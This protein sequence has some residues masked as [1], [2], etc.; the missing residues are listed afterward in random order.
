M[1][2][3]PADGDAV[4]KHSGTPRRRQRMA[5][6]RSELSTSKGLSEPPRRRKR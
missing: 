3:E 6:D 1:I 2:D 5:G 4:P